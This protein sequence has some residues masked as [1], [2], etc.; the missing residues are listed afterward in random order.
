MGTTY[1]AAIDSGNGGETTIVADSDDAAWAQ[2]KV[3]ARAGEWEDGGSV[4]VSV[5]D[6][7]RTVRV[8]NVTINVSKG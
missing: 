7:E 5:Y 3:W 8:D 2:A 1:R 4:L 6:G